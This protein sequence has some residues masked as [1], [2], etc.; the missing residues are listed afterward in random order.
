MGPRS[1]HMEKKGWNEDFARV[2]KEKATTFFFT[3]FL[4]TWDEKALW[5]L[6]AKHGTVVDVHLAARRIKVGTRFGFVQFI[7]VGN[8]LAFEQKLG[9]ICIGN[10]K[11]LI[12]IAKYDKAGHYLLDKENKEMKYKG[13]QWTFGKLNRDKHK[14]QD[15]YTKDNHANHQCHGKYFKEAMTGKE[16][17]TNEHM[18]RTEVESAIEIQPSHEQMSRL[19]RCWVGET[20]NIHVLRNIWT[21]MKQDGL[22]DCCIHYIGGLSILGEWKSEGIARDCL[23][24]NKVNLGNWFSKLVMWEESV[25]PPGRLTWLEIEGLPALIWVSN[26]V[27]KIVREVGLVLEIDD[28]ELDCSIKNSVGVL[29]YTNVMEEI[30]KCIPVRVNGRIYQI[31]ILEDHNR[32]ILLNIP[33]DTTNKSC[34]EEYIDGSEDEESKGISETKFGRIKEASF[35]GVKLREGKDTVDVDISLSR[36]APTFKM[37]VEDVDD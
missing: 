16:M 24:R 10:P 2:M 21:L 20:R 17:N 14:Q 18:N 34:N 9:E 30:N 29:I 5:K 8:I 12:N 28:M 1:K 4:N 25:E 33:K 35:S 3:R 22:G 36:V 15:T 11:I 7:K 13:W 32:S 6:F 31:R 27:C 19:R 23:K 26:A 37:V